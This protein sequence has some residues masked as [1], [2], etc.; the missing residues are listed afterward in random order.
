MIPFLVL[1]FPLLFVSILDVVSLSL[2]N[3][4]LSAGMLW[5][6]LYVSVCQSVGLSVCMSIGNA[7]QV[8]LLES[9]ISSRVRR[10]TVRVRVGR[11]NIK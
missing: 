10:T 8:R 7:S 5:V 9:D 11:C 4:Y 3:F 2:R 6:Y 1:S